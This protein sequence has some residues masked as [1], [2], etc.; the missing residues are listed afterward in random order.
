MSIRPVKRVIQYQNIEADRLTINFID[1]PA[2]QDP[3]Q[4]VIPISNVQATL[5]MLASAVESYEVRGPRFRRHLREEP[6][7]VTEPTKDKRAGIDAS[8]FPSIA[9]DTACR[10]SL[11]AAPYSQP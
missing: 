11:A 10:V 3:E 1:S 5:E 7:K 9:S 4:I 2:R 8:V 6:A